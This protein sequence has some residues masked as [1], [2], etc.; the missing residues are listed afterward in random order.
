MTWRCCPFADRPIWPAFLQ[1]RGI[2]RG[3]YC[4]PSQL[5]SFSLRLC[6]AF[7]CS[8]LLQVAR[9]G[10]HSRALQGFRHVEAAQATTVG[11]G[12]RYVALWLVGVVVMCAYPIQPSADVDGREEEYGTSQQAARSCI[13]LHYN[14]V[15]FSC[16]NQMALWGII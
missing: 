9:G 4:L 14:S 2:G 11:G 13:V 5:L 12:R 8:V 6:P 1:E 15:S 10:V 16:V 7:V 3:N